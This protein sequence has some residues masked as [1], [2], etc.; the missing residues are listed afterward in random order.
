MALSEMNT[1][2]KRGVRL[3][4]AAVDWRAVQIRGAREGRH[5]M[6]DQDD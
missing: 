4:A 2:E 3:S 1:N 6:P 5:E